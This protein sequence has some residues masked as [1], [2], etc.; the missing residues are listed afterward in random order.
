MQLEVVQVLVTPKPVKLSGVPRYTLI[1][2][3]NLAQRRP[4][5]LPAKPSRKSTIFNLLLNVGAVYYFILSGN[6]EQLQH[7][8]KCS[9]QL[10]K[11]EYYVQ[12]C[13]NT[14]GPYSA[15]AGGGREP[16]G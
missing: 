12:T 7:F 5:E 16:P 13:L 4:S 2:V 14:C 8:I 10:R 1:W 6:S 3:L 9:K 11:R 15:P